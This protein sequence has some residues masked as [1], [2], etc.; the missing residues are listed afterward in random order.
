M[1]I[2]V[3]SIQTGLEGCDIESLL[4]N[5]FDVGALRPFSEIDKNKNTVNSISV[6]G[7]NINVNN[8]TLRK[9]EW[10]AYDEALIPAY[11]MPLV[12]VSYVMGL[13]LTYN[14]NNPLGTTILQYEDMS[15]VRGA[16]HSM[17]VPVQGQNDIPEFDLKS[18]PI[19][20]ISADFQ[21]DI[22]KLHA[23]RTTGQ[24]LDT[25]IAA[26]KTQ[27][28]A[29]YLENSFFWG[30]GNA[31]K[32]VTGDT[33]NA[34]SAIDFGTAANVAALNMNFGGGSVTGLMTAPNRTVISTVYTRWD[35]SAKTGPQIKNDVLEMIEEAK[36]T[37]FNGPYVLWIPDAYAVKLNDDYDVSGA[38][39]MTIRERL[40]KIKNL[41]IMETPALGMTSTT[42]DYHHM[43][44]MQ[45][46]MQTCRIIKG[47][48]ATMMEWSHGGTMSSNFRI[49]SIMVPQFR[50]T[51]TGVM[52]IIMRS[53]AV[54]S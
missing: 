50:G 38:S 47:F 26:L 16:S 44:L 12:A 35:N 22:R 40:A 11:Q 45:A 9:D 31:Y 51:Q 32:V 5:N 53:T 39:L 2:N 13:G 25:T 17:D 28:I 21:I 46:D 29:E 41:T 15:D 52:G 24:S 42:G 6:N 7:K 18:I 48:G 1:K 19:P 27:K 37:G 36:G 10:I 43:A 30:L 8:A 3:A 4:A 14:L 23:S 34:V 49:M 33:L 20:I 54:I